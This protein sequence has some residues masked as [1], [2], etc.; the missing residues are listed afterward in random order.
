MMLFTWTRQRYSH[1]KFESHVKHFNTERFFNCTNLILDDRTPKCYFQGISISTGHKEKRGM[2]NLTLRFSTTFFLFFTA[3]SRGKSHM[4]CFYTQS[5]NES[6]CKLFQKDKNKGRKTDRDAGKENME[7]LKQSE[8]N[9][10]NWSSDIR[11][12]TIAT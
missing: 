11:T 7:I 10:G 8:G 6:F 12:I 4:L 9:N 2:Q 1:F 5:A 3:C